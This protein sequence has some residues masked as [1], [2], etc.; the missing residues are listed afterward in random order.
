MS[1]LIGI[2]GGGTK[3]VGLLANAQGEVLAEARGPGANLRSHGELH[4]EKVF[5]K[6]LEELGARERQVSAMCLGLA[7]VTRPDD[8]ALIKDMLRRM[9]HRMPVHVVHDA[10]IALAAGA[11]GGVGIVVLS[12]TG[13]I[14]YGADAS[15]A[16]ARAGGRGHL[17]ADEGSAFWFG[18]QALRM[19]VRG[20]DG[21][22]PETRLRGLVFEALGIT[23]IHDLVPY[24]AERGFPREVIAALAR[25]VQ[26][27][28]DA[29]DTGAQDLIVRGA[30]ELALAACA[31]HHK[32]RF[33]GPFPVVLAGGA[34][35]ACPGLVP[36]FEAALALP[37][38]RPA[39]LQQEPAYGAVV[40][41]RDLAR[42]V[43]RSG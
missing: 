38:A 22:G 34:F 4:V 17:T 12:G 35:K 16:N 42:G 28:A 11:P 25:L 41:A 40:L 43:A 3:T 36:R 29:G 1:Y 10:L 33:D 37:D 20:D 32:L 15:G 24:L 2:D 6:I 14:A 39:L 13:S 31:V 26:Q 9:G 8:Q 18:H 21:R 19:V 5:D 27:A 23:Q 7:G 30:E